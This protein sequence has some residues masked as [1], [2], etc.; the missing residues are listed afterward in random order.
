MGPRLLGRGFTSVKTES[1]EAE[2]PVPR[3]L[4]DALSDHRKR[5]PEAKLFK[6]NGWQDQD[7]IFTTRE[8][9]SLPHWKLSARWHPEICKVAGRHV[10]LHAAK[11]RFIHPGRDGRQPI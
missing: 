5:Q 11:N 4:L 8:G 7:L 1:S 6:G 3:V 10:S 2:G 9:M